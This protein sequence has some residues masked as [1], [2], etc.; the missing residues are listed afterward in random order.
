[1]E[2]NSGKFDII[3]YYIVNKNWVNLFLFIFL[4]VIY[5]YGIICKLLVIMSK[6]LFVLKYIEVCL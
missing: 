4:R 2:Y 3:Y 6:L 5:L 1:M